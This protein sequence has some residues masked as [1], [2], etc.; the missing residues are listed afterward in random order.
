[1]TAAPLLSIIVPAFNRRHHITYTLD[2]LL[3]Q[4]CPDYEVIVVDDG[5][6]DGTADVVRG[7]GEAVRLHVRSNAERGAARNYGTRTAKGRYVNWFDSDDRALPNHVE[8]IRRAVDELEEPPW[9]H[10]D[11]Y[12]ERESSHA[13]DRGD[14]CAIWLGNSVSC[15]AGVVRRDVALGNPFREERALAGSEDWELWLR[16][17]AI[18]GRRNVPVATSVIIDH[19]ARSVLSQTSGQLLARQSALEQAV[20]ENP[21]TSAFIDGHRR[22]FLAACRAYFALHLALADGPPRHALAL[23]GSAVRHDRRVLTRRSTLAT[24]KPLVLRRIPYHV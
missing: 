7:Y 18:H 16:L 14:P 12:V 10:L 1:M 5:S 11:H 17:T 24:L 21:I 6:T 9:F 23:L 19:P 2:S 15:N 13:R 4:S 22:E 20:L 8:T 3:Q